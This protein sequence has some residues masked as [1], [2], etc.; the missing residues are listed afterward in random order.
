MLHVCFLASK[1]SYSWISASDH[2]GGPTWS[3]FLVAECCA[4]SHAWLVFRWTSTVTSATTVAPATNRKIAFPVGNLEHS[5]SSANYN[6]CCDNTQRSCCS[7]QPHYLQH[8]YINHCVHRA[9]MGSVLTICNIV[10]THCIPQQQL[11]VCIH[12]GSH[13]ECVMLNLV[14]YLKQSPHPSGWSSAVQN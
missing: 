9:C 3:C 10:C 7:W 2:H 12:H 5:G 4:H 14:T 13:A 11:A 6:L 8:S 1:P